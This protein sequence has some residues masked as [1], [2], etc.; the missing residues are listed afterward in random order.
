M[1]E[2]AHLLLGKEK[3]AKRV[4]TAW[5]GLVI[6]VNFQINDSSKLEQT[7]PTYGNLE[8]S[9]ASPLQ[10]LHERDRLQQ[11]DGEYTSET[12]FLR[13]GH[14]Q[15]QD[16][17]DRQQQDPDIGDE[18]KDERHGDMLYRC[19]IALALDPSRWLKMIAVVVLQ[20]IPLHGPALE[21][22]KPRRTEHPEHDIDQV[23][24][25]SD[26]QPFLVD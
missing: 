15:L 26:A 13:V 11:S 20:P 16:G 6:C 9:K 8:V 21:E 1:H 22:I 2:L 23:D 5:V 3:R 7:S 19:R 24:P 4:L 17:R 12:Q 18:A 10:C 25:P 14:L